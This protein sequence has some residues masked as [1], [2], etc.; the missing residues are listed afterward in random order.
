MRHPDKMQALVDYAAAVGAAR[1]SDGHGRIVCAGGDWEGEHLGAHE[2]RVGA[3]TLSVHPAPGMMPLAIAK[4]IEGCKRLLRLL[5][6]PIPG[7]PPRGGGDGGGPA[8]AE[9]RVWPPRKQ[10]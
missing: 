4:R 2:L 7:L 3:Y 8:P 9:L 5:P 6:A 10:W 1:L